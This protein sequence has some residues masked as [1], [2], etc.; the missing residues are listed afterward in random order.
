MRRYINDI[1]KLFGNDKKRILRLFYLFVGA[2]MVDIL[3]LG[4]I[5]P[6]IS[7]IS[8]DG[9]SNETLNSLIKNMPPNEII[10]YS[11]AGLLCVF[12]IKSFIALVINWKI[13]DF[14]LDQQ[15]S[16]R[17]LLM[18]SYQF[19]PYADHVEKNSASNI[20]HIQQ[21]TNQYSMQ[22]LIPILRAI[23]EGF[24][25]LFI[26]LFLA[27]TNIRA[28]ATLLFLLSF[29]I[30]IYDRVFRLKIRNYGEEANKAS[31]LMVKSIQESFVGFKEIRIL[32]KEKYLFNIFK[33]NAYENAFYIK[34]SQI[35]STIPRYMFELIIIIFV[36]CVVLASTLTNQNK[37][38]L[39]SLLAIFGVASLRLIPAANL[40]AN[41]LTQLRYNRDT[42]TRLLKDVEEIKKYNYDFEFKRDSEFKKIELNKVIFSHK[43]SQKISTNNVSL[44]ITSG[45]MIG[46]IGNS[47][48][49]K[50]TLVDLM[51]GL[52]KPTSGTI[53]Y[54]EISLSNK[55]KEWQ[56]QVAYLPQKAFLVDDSIRANVALGIRR[57]DIDET[58]LWDSLGKARLHEFVKNLPDGINTSV[59]ES[60]DRLSGGQRQR[61]ALARA[62]YYGRDV[63]VMDEATSALDPLTEHE[64]IDDIS[65]QKGKMTVIIITHK[66]KNIENCDRVYKLKSGSIS[67]V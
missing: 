65:R 8:G 29:S 26:F 12:I 50:T 18:T 36:V 40:F 63:L 56:S 39:A 7:L 48:S 53:L 33:K 37:E 54:N 15:L 13:I 30:F 49:G 14:S 66:M 51:L 9:Y 52:L 47:G 59:G 67:I 43:N 4:L 32:G 6:Y 55:M 25:V 61:V 24:I 60:G 3:G 46:I 16:L 58:R 34:K 10:I 1:F 11:S 19:L 2:S 5:S 62:F 17:S 22:V 31:V 44:K 64:I 35:F 20:Y 57:K 42:V 41:C 45:E 23:G 38:E 28:L 21:L 27:W